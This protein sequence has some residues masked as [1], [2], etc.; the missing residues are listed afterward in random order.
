MRLSHIRFLSAKL[1]FFVFSASSEPLV[2]TS[3]FF[4]VSV[5]A[6]FLFLF[7][8]ASCSFSGFATCLATFGV[9]GSCPSLDLL[10]FSSVFL[11]A[12]LS[13]FLCFGSSTPLAATFLF[14]VLDC[15][16]CC[17]FSCFSFSF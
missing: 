2:A 3:L 1:R 12:M 14:L 7:F 6:T 8:S 13:S 5:A 9:H 15:L 11:S 4:F 10:R 17:F 16:P